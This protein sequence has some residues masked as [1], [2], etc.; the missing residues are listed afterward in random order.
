[1]HRT[2]G[3]GPPEVDLCGLGF[4][5]SSIARFRNR[6]GRFRT[7]WMGVFKPT[8]VT[9]NFSEATSHLRYRRGKRVVCHRASRSSS[10]RKDPVLPTDHTAHFLR[11]HPGLADK[12]ERPSGGHIPG[13]PR[14]ATIVWSLRD[15]QTC[16]LMLTS[17][18]DC[19]RA[20]A[21]THLFA[22]VRD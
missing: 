12:T 13:I 11:R 16:V 6:L 2:G 21:K 10:L 14:L 18:G 1:M 20:P 4:L 9:F 5:V 3:A 22:S 15:K 17:M 19:R 8:P 7:R